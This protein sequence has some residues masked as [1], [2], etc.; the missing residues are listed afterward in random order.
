M[1]NQASRPLEIALEN[2]DTLLRE[3][4]SRNISED[5]RKRFARQ[6]RDAIVERCHRGMSHSPSL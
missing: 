2:L 5:Q 3:I 1:A 6:L 4:K